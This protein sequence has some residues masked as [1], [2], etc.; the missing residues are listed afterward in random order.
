L[1]S[2]CKTRPWRALGERLHTVIRSYDPLVYILT[3][4]NQ[5]LRI[6]R[7]DK[8][9][10]EKVFS[11]LQL[12]TEVFDELEKIS[13][14]TSNKVIPM[15]SIV[16]NMLKNSIDV[17]DT[18]IEQGVINDLC[19][20]ILNQMSLKIQTSIH[21]IHYAASFLDPAFKTF[22]YL[23]TPDEAIEIAKKFIIMHCLKDIV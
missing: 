10:L 7:I 1:Q 3:S 9:L 2:G 20:S 8:K 21:Q 18:S 5:H 4:S 16:R 6:S 22:D 19:N 14:P 23:E 15:V 12:F 11:I 17:N 13:E